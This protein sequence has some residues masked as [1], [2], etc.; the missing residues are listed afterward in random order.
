MHVALLSLLRHRWHLFKG[1]REDEH[2]EACALGDKVV[3]AR[4]QSPDRGL[5]TMLVP[6]APTT[7]LPSL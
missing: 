5:P 2:R 4:R 3:G 6:L 7:T 1:D